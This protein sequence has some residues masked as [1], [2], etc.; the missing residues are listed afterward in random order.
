MVINHVSKSW[1]DPP[2]GGRPKVTQL[3]QHIDGLGAPNNCG[4]LVVQ[5]NWPT[6]LYWEPYKKG[7]NNIGLWSGLGLIEIPSF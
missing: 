3:H 7:G 4:V 2:S 5:T 6:P 1:D